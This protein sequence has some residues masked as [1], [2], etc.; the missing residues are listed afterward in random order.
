MCKKL[1]QNLCSVTVAIAIIVTS[2]LR[3]VKADTKTLDDVWS[4]LNSIDQALTA[5]SSTRSG[6]LIYKFTQLKN[7]FEYIFGTSASGQGDGHINYVYNNQSVSGS[8]FN[9]AMGDM[10]SQQNEILMSLVSSYVDASDPDNVIVQPGLFDRLTTIYNA[11][12]SSATSDATIA[13]YIDDIT[14]ETQQIRSI[15]QNMN[16]YNIPLE[17]LVAYNYFIRYENASISV[18][19]LTK[20]PIVNIKESVSGAYNTQR[21]IYIPADKTL[22]IAFL[23][24]SNDSIDE[25]SMPAYALNE[26]MQAGIDVSYKFI[27]I[28]NTRRMIHVIVKNNFGSR[29][30]LSFD[31]TFTSKTIIPFYVGLEELMSDEMQS[32]IMYYSRESNYQLLYDIRD[33]VYSSDDGLSWLQKIYNHLVGDPDSNNKTQQDIDSMNQKVDQLQTSLDGYND[34]FEAVQDDVDPSG[35]LTN[36]QGYSNQIG[37]GRNLIQDIYNSFGDIKW[38]FL[39]PLMIGLILLFVG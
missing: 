32:A 35:L 18:N 12:S 38:L 13:S 14:S 28:S 36:I 1:W 23:I 8:T 9:Q 11:V 3:P 7:D 5:A 2:F 34:Q 37:R 6:D 15:L 20:Y 33:A 17:S 24:Y 39:L 10:I 21:R 30:S 31:F 26:T 4:M 22:V 19:S 27:S 29:V 16:T 25:N